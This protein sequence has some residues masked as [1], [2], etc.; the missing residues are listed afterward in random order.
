MYID[1]VILCCTNIQITVVV[2]SLSIA[3]VHVSQIVCLLKLDD[4]IRFR[5]V[6]TRIWVR[7]TVRTDL[8]GPWE[9]G[10]I[11]IK[12]ALLKYLLCWKYKVLRSD[13]DTV[14]WYLAIVEWS[15]AN[16]SQIGF[17]S[18]SSAG[19]VALDVNHDVV[20]FWGPFVAFVSSFCS[21]AW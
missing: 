11:R 18:P 16:W 3:S 14:L 8:T 9:G 2:V 17:W 13:Q 7:C 20:H 6:W 15:A 5:L 10:W 1:Q 4:K 19:H 21:C 12:H